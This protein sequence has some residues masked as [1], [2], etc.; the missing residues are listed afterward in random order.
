MEEGEEKE[1]KKR[2]F[3]SFFFFFLGLDLPCWLC[4]GLQMLG[5]ITG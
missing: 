2:E 1:R 3:A 5:A 4:W